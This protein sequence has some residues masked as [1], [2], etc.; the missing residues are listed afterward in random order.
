MGECFLY[1]SELWPVPAGFI[2]TSNAPGLDLGREGGRE[3]GTEGGREGRREGGELRTDLTHPQ[4]ISNYVDQDGLELIL[5]RDRV[6]G[7]L[8]SSSPVLGPSSGLTQAD[9]RKGERGQGEEERSHPIGL[10][11]ESTPSVL[12]ATSNC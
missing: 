3:G 5:S 2:L 12:P 7:F 11:L 1:L 9:F 6:S 8:N 4:L 10:A